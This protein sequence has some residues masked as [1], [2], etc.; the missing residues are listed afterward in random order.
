LR[1]KFGEIITGVCCMKHGFGYLSGH[2]KSLL[3]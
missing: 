3:K 2:E 1:G